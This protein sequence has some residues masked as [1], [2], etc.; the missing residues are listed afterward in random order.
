LFRREIKMENMPKCYHGKE[1]EELFK[2]L[3]ARCNGEQ[4]YDGQ[5]HSATCPIK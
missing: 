1:C 4:I 2:T 3:E 5:G